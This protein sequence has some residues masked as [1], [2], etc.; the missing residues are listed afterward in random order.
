MTFDELNIII[1]KLE[2]KRVISPY[3]SNL[4]SQSKSSPTEE[5]KD[6]EMEE[7]EFLT[8]LNRI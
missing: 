1:N 6:E 8:K 7:K 3:H 4:D 5:K 2:P